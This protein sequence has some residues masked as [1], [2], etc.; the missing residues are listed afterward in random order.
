MLDFYKLSCKRVFI[1]CK[2]IRY[3]PKGLGVSREGFMKGNKK[4]SLLGDTPGDLAD[5]VR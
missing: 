4:I 5:A 3:F 2:N 1:F